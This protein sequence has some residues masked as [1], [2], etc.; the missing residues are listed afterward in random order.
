MDSLDI[1]AELQIIG[2][3]LKLL[4]G[5]LLYYAA[6]W[7][8]LGW[9]TAQLGPGRQGPSWLWPLYLQV[10]L[11]IALLGWLTIGIFILETVR[12]ILM[13][14][15]STTGHI[16]SWSADINWRLVV[17]L[18]CTL[19]LLAFIF[20]GLAVA[21]YGSACRR[22]GTTRTHRA[23]GRGG[24]WLARLPRVD[25]RPNSPGLVG[26]CPWPGLAARHLHS[27]NYRFTAGVL[28]LGTGPPP[29]GLAVG[30]GVT[31]PA[32]ALPDRARGRSGR[33]PM[34]DPSMDPCPCRVRASRPTV[35]RRAIAR[36]GIP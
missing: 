15:I 2:T 32:L 7:L 12:Q 16:V 6:P 22:G 34:E 31:G 30:P 4:M 25:G 5:F 26:R 24:R 9:V 29:H 8:L 14:Q 18:S 17:W 11:G 10:A 23:R 28:P 19:G 3:E 13:E 35:R 27:G 36:V 1:Y 33:T 20:L 21:K